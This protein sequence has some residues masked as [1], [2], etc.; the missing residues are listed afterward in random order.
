MHDGLSRVARVGAPRCSLG[1]DWTRPQRRG[2]LGG[3]LLHAMTNG[4]TEKRGHRGE[5]SAQPDVETLERGTHH[6]E[7]NSAA[8]ATA[9]CMSRCSDETEGASLTRHQTPIS[10]GMDL[11]RCL[12]RRLRSVHTVPASPRFSVKVVLDTLDDEHRF[13]DRWCVHNPSGARMNGVGKPSCNGVLERSPKRSKK[14]QK[15]PKRP[16]R[17]LFL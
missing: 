6:Q 13:G 11:T 15:G 3:C 1:C 10:L 7:N 14:V 17:G 5:E 16:K 4:T 9:I 2:C 12:Q 8:R